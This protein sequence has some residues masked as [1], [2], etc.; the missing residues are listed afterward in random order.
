MRDTAAGD[1]VL[2][3]LRDIRLPDDLR[4]GLRPKPASQDRVMGAGGIHERGAL[5]EGRKNA[6][7]KKLSPHAPESQRLGL[8]RLRPDPVGRGP[9][10]F[11]DSFSS[12]AREMNSPKGVLHYRVRP[13]HVKQ[14]GS[15]AA[16]PH[17]VRN[18]KSFHLAKGRTCSGLE[19]RVKSA[20]FTG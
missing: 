4:K 12:P 16:D 8:L 15:I 13:T 20:Y 2:E 18:S 3:G 1:R 7:D 17:R 9:T 14:L 19:S 11:G 10:A 5:S 6:G